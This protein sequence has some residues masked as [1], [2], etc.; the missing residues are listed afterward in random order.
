MQIAIA[1]PSSSLTRHGL[2]QHKQP[3]RNRLERQALG[4]PCVSYKD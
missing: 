2:K 4:W 1:L 3:E